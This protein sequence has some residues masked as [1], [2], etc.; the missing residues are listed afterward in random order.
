MDGYTLKQMVDENLAENAERLAKRDQESRIPWH[1]R[2]PE[3]IVEQAMVPVAPGRK[4]DQLRAEW[5]AHVQSD[6]HM[7]GGL[8]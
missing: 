7:P 5:G 1:L 6:E 4:R 2:V 3:A 8:R